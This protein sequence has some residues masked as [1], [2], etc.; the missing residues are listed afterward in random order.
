MGHEVVFIHKDDRDWWDDIQDLKEAAPRRLTLDECAKE[1]LLDI[2]IESSFFVSARMRPSVAKRCIWYNRRPALFTDIEGTVYGCKPEGRDLEGISA[3]WTADIYTKSDDIVYLQTLYPTIPIHVVPWIWTPEIVESHRKTSQSPVWIQTYQG[4]PV[5][6]PWSI[7]VAESNASSTSSCTL[8]LVIMRHM[9]SS[10]TTIKTKPLISRV[11]IHN[12]D[13]LQSNQ[14]FKE[15]VVKHCS[16]P[17]LSYNMIGRQRVIDWV[18][19]PHSILLSHSRFVPLKMANLEAAW[20][21]LPVV[22]NSE[23][24]RDIGHGLEMLYYSSN[25][26]TGAGAALQ[27]IIHNIH[28]VSYLSTI[29]GLTEVRKQ[30]IGRFYPQMRMDG[31]AQALEK[32]MNISVPIVPVSVPMAMATPVPVPVPMAMAT[33]VNVKGLSI[34]F[35]DMWDQFN[36]SYNMFTL[37]LD[38]ALQSKNILTSGY[39]L[40]SLPKDTKP[41]LVIFGPFGEA[42]KDLP[43]EWPKVHF[44]GENTEPITNNDSVK[45]NIGYKLPD[46]S[47]DT[48]LRMPLWQFE[49]D[50]FGAD[51]TKL[52]NPLPL[53]IDTCTK[54]PSNTSSRSKFCAFI[55]TNPKNT[56][57][58]EAFQILNAYKP[59]SSAGRLFNNIGD[60]IFAGLGGGGGELKKHEFLK[61]YRF[62]IS[63]ENASSPGYT[64]EKILHAKAAG[65]I[66]IYWGDPKIGRDFNEKGF[67]NANNCKSHSDLVELVSA[68]ENNPASLDAMASVPALSIY[69]RDLVRR[70]FAEM[71]RRLLIFAGRRELV[72]GL[73]SFLGAKTTDEALALRKKR[74]PLYNPVNTTVSNT[75]VSNTTVSNTTVSN[76]VFVTGATQRFWPYVLMWLNSLEAHKTTIPTLKVRVYVGA[77][78]AES[79]IEMS[80]EKY[81]GVEFIRF[82][83]ETPQGFSDFWNPLHYAWKL[84]IYNTVVNDPILK[85]SLVFYMDVA[86]VL[87]RWPL[88]W[89]QQA[90]GSGVSFLD[91]CRQKNSSWCHTK[92]CQALSVSQAELDSQQIAAC[93]ILF[94]AGH[95]TATKLFTEA[96]KL[97]QQRDIVVGE[98]WAG[99]NSD[100]KPFGHRHDQSILSILSQRYQCSRFPIDKVYGDRSARATFHNGQA[101]YVHRG[102]FQTHQPIIPGIDDAFVINLDRRED[103]KK[104]F[105]ECNPDLRGNVRRLPAYDAKKLTLTPYLAR[106]FTTNDFFWKKAVMGC[107]LSHLKLWTM[108]VNESQDIQS[109]LI[110]EDDARLKPGWREAWARAYPSLPEDWDCVYLGGI[111]PPN[112]PAFLE[113][114]ERVAPGLARVVPNQIFGQKEPTRYFHFCA[115]AYVLSRRGAAKILESI[116]DRNGYWTSADHMICNRVDAMNLYVLDPL[117]AGASQDD[118]PIYQKAEF[119]NFSRV[120]SFDSD[121][122]NN[123][124][125]FTFEE[126][127]T[128][129]K[130]GAPLHLSATFTE[131]DQPVQP[132]PVPVA[133]PVAQAVAQA[134]REGPRF[135]ALST[136]IDNG[137]TLYESKWLQDLFQTVTFN[138][139]L[140]SETDT[141]NTGDDLNV[142][143]IKTKWQEQLRWLER[144]RCVHS[145]KLIHLSDE[146]GNDPIHMYSWPEVTGVLRFYC[147]SDLPNDPK[148]LVVP[149]GYHWQY[150]GNRDVPHLSTPNLPFREN[151]W[152]FAGTDW[153]N[154]SNDLEVLRAI[155]PHYLKYFADWKDPN[156]LKEEEYISLLLNTKFIP[157]PRGQ[158]VETYRFYEA[159]DCGCIPLFIDSP[160]INEWLQ[161][162]NNE[163]P[164]LKLPSWEYTVGL[165]HHFQENVEQMEKYRT[166]I[167]IAWAK[168]KIGLKERVR[169]WLSNGKN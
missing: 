115:Y 23:I 60:S 83:T 128:Q 40:D 1:G 153:L 84:W 95:P 8:P 80:A 58:N 49:I 72:S 30:I 69:T 55:V 38:N 104:T 16:V 137:N 39:S 54:G 81:K 20:V 106:L 154:R 41:D 63:Y 105:L 57:R 129:M 165:L 35:T 162:F 25:S 82:P 134:V 102:N 90:Q 76:T 88:E 146:Y 157:C 123:D 86:T 111:L 19:D 87:L 71:V 53:P 133:Q 22:H 156:Q 85:G 117:V 151:T 18:Y 155:Q 77:D 142:L 168:Y 6:T 107:A 144:L 28:S 136:C 74:E 75:T 131:I 11:T 9:F 24:L 65:C 143:I 42:W 160:E 37:A 44:T 43:S 66:P 33:P 96:Y 15:N 26:V 46:I 108:L 122:W 91:D 31:W 97:G 103:R 163:I 150:K 138:V 147:R 94:V 158:N 135:I 5:D 130:K 68:L 62:C 167:L 140:V 2:L 79:T 124:E 145:F 59:V 148:I 93:L 14:F 21:G 67:L 47:D 114:L 101:V 112:K 51:L 121:L 120:D 17:D 7:H 89:I 32:T 119:N 152:S 127:E 109:L 92:F 3:I 100:G 110:L 27:K 164:F 78:V 139:E 61:D 4:V 52:R 118:D 99:V 45:L 132:V 149:L 113:S 126:I 13:L 48:Y 10:N 116:L 161:V 70:N 56:V 98:K 169:K 159:L 29:E 36:E 64:T 73:P 141:F 34:L 50:W 166:N 125:R 12:T